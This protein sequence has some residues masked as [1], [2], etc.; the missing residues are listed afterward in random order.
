MEKLENWGKN[1]HSFPTRLEEIKYNRIR[2][3]HSRFTNKFMAAGDD[4]PICLMCN[5]P[6]T[7]LHIFTECPLYAEARNRFF[8]GKFFKGIMSRKSKDNC[9]KVINFLKYTD[10]FY[11]I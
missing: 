4:S 11:E 2:L 3:G 9:I 7:I 10:L 6:I 1:Y 8:P 5:C